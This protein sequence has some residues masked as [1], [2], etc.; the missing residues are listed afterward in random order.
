MSG[1]VNERV[2]PSTLSQQNFVGSPAT[3]EFDPDP[4]LIGIPALLSLPTQV[5]TEIET[6]A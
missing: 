2:K 1:W 6:L 4:F 5:L 3:K